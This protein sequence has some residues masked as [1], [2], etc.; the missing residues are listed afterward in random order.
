MKLTVQ[1]LSV[2]L[3]GGGTWRL[4]LNVRNAWSRTSISRIRLRCDWF[5]LW[6]HNK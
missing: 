3:K 1:E 4:S 2:Q 6:Q 5:V